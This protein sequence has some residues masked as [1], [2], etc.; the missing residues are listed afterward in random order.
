[1]QSYKDKDYKIQA[2]TSENVGEVLQRVIDV[3]ARSSG[4]EHPGLACD[5]VELWFA[6]KKM[7]RS[8]KLSDYVGR[9]EKTQVCLMSEFF[10]LMPEILRSNCMHR[11]F[12]AA[13]QYFTGDLMLW[14]CDRQL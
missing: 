13:H 6:Q 5:M 4:D 14:W 11:S 9:I 7:L 8:R 2:S 12:G 1:M 10:L 3:I